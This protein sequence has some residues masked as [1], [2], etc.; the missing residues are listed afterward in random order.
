MKKRATAIGLLFTTLASTPVHAFLD[1]DIIDIRYLFPNT[2]T[3]FES[4]DDLV[5]GDD[6]ELICSGT[7]TGTGVCT[8]NFN[9]NFLN[10]VDLDPAGNTVSILWAG[11][12]GFFTRDFNGFEITQLDEGIAGAT[13][14]CTAV[15]GGQ[16]SPVVTFGS[17]PEL[18]NF[19]R[20]N[21]GAFNSSA[22]ITSATVTVTPCT[23]GLDSDGDAV[24]DD[25]DNCLLAVNPD[26]FDA[27][28]DGFG[29][30]CD[31]DINNDGAVNF[32]D[33]G[34][35]RDVFFSV[36]TDGNWAPGADFNND[37]AVNFQDLGLMRAGFF[38]PP[39][40]SCAL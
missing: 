24:N 29:N 12:A 22:G 30:A 7:G 6:A 35:L 4:T 14:E 27:D 1:G 8:V 11:G 13:V 37:G 33:L 23:A 17:S 32:E 25:V 38:D 10:N 16:C 15:G 2:E 18:G 34:L 36:P 19:L 5:I 40:P 39:G 31:Q 9:N 20:I 21:Y 26:Q 28:G 3:V